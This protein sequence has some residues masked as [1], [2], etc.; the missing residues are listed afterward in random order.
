MDCG[1]F[2][3]DICYTLPPPGELICVQVGC[4]HAEPELFSFFGGVLTPDFGCLES[5][6]AQ[7]IIA[8]DITTLNSA[9]IYNDSTVNFA[10]FE[11]N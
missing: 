9:H 10:S 2:E 3:I 8:N 7:V 5:Q 4:I 1:W 11:T 6:V